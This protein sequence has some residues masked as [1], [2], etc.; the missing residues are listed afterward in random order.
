MHLRDNA[1]LE[2]SAE[3]LDNYVTYKHGKSRRQGMAGVPPRFQ[4]ALHAYLQFVGE[5]GRALVRAYHADRETRFC[6]ST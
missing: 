4:F 2:L 6:D 3:Q 1:T 5:S